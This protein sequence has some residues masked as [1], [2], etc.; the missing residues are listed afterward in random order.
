MPCVVPRS[1]DLYP[2]ILAYSCR[3]FSTDRTSCNRKNIHRRVHQ[4]IGDIGA[5]IYLGAESIYNVW[6]FDNDRNS[7]IKTS[8]VQFRSASNPK[9]KKVCFL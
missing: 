6:L 8:P 3:V 7:R 1:T 4:Y 9:I 5:L 2:P